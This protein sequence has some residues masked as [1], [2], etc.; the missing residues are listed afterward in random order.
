MKIIDFIKKEERLKD[1]G[2]RP[3]QK[4][5]QYEKPYKD[6]NKKKQLIKSVII[7][8]KNRLN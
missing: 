4:I 3:V 1:L 6:L 2:L 5:K 8:E 7:V